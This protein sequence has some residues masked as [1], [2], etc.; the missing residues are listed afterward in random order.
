MPV[1]LAIANSLVSLTLAA[2]THKLFKVICRLDRLRTAHSKNQIA[3]I[4]GN[5]ILI[6]R[7]RI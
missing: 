1:M 2:H 7:P 3:I 6:G 4:M 5:G